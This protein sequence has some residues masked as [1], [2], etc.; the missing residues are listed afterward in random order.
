VAPVD[1]ATL[2]SQQRW[3]IINAQAFVH[4][5][6]GCCVLHMYFLVRFDALFNRKRR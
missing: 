3:S 1:R 5:G 6:A 4:D 2:A